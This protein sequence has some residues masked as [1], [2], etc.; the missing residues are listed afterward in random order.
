[1]RLLARSSNARVI[2][3][4]SRVRIV[5]PVSSKTGTAARRGAEV[6]RHLRLR[7]ED[8]SPKTKLKSSG[9]GDSNA[10]G[11]ASGPTDA[12][13]TAP[14][15]P[16][17]TVTTAKLERERLRAETSPA[18][19]TALRL[20]GLLD[21][22]E[23]A[24]DPVRPEVQEAVDQEISPS[25][26]EEERERAYALVN[27]YVDDVGGLGDR[28]INASA[29]PDRAA[30]LLDDAG[31]PTIAAE[32]EEAAQ[33]L[34]EM[35]GDDERRDAF[36]E[37][38]DQESEV[39]QRHFVD[40]VL[41][42][43]PNALSD[44]L[45]VDDIMER[46]DDGDISDES[47]AIVTE[48]VAEDFNR[49][50]I[51]RDTFESMY[52]IDYGPDQR[53]E[54]DQLLRFVGAS[55]GDA[56]ARMRATLS[57]D[58]LQTWDSS[59]YP[60]NLGFNSSNA[61]Q[62]SLALEM[63]AGDPSRP[64]I[65][66]NLL[67][68]Q[69]EDTRTKVL[70]VAGQLDVRGRTLPDPMATIFDAVGRDSSPGAERLARE[71]ARLPGEQSDWFDGDMTARNDAL[72]VMLNGHSTAILD[73]LTE[74]DDTGARGLGNNT[75]RKQYEVNGRDLAAL[76]ELT[77]LNPEVDD[78]KKQQ[79]Q[80][81]ILDY[82]ND[83][84]E[85]I[86]RSRNVD[87]SPGFEDASGR[88]VVLSAAT[89]VAVTRGFEALKD[90]REAQRNAIGFGV[91]L[92]LAAVPLS[93]RLN[94]A[95]AN[96]ISDLFPSG[97]LINDALKGFTGQLINSRTGRLTTAA[98]NHILDAVQSDP[99]L[100]E[101]FERQAIGDVFRE[102]ILQAIYDERD[103]ADLRRDANDLAKDINDIS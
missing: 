63:A 5:G 103:R 67:N 57:Q 56:T 101:L 64:E 13:E 51:D 11:E 14:S 43:D 100:A 95:A 47:L 79:A 60:T 83:Q 61:T 66:T 28:G 18:K 96:Q 58:I 52:D 27:D 73:E 22:R 34:T 70:H 88:I 55:D 29:L 98:R 16:Q 42:S 12:A 10:S 26:T 37:T 92:A 7:P 24:N 2:D 36:V 21:E 93:S 44:W 49:G 54:A 3:S 91:D 35:D 20:Q 78:V 69:D 75:D 90:D 15:S 38:L 33:A 1:M 6:L 30:Q 53:R 74:Y 81:A 39:Y 9:P 72:A 86:E 32:A 80:D 65:L 87:G 99:E 46:Y 45:G 85:I 102:S 8:K 59:P 62:F 50:Q 89:D 68:A 31:I 94:A 77:V 17:P 23:V 41:E 48:E 76:M 97:S 25:A 19:M 40:A 82:V 4:Q 71:L 84:A